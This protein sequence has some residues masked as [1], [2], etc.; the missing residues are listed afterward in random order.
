MRVRAEPWRPPPRVGRD[1]G[2]SAPIGIPAK[3][4][5]AEPS[6]RMRRWPGTTGPG[7]TGALRRGDWPCTRPWPCA[8]SSPPRRGV[9]VAHR[10][11][12]A[13]RPG[14]EGRVGRRGHLV[15]G[16]TARCP[17]GAELAG[18]PAG[19]RK[20]PAGPSPVRRHPASPRASPPSP[21]LRR[22]PPVERRSVGTW[23]PAGAPRRTGAGAA[24]RR[25][26]GRA[27]RQA[28]GPGRVA[29]SSSMPVSPYSGRV[30]SLA[31]LVMRREAV[32]GA[33]TARSASSP[34]GR[35]GHRGPSA[36][37]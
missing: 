3:G 36:M 27:A 4:S 29:L 13:D 17:A 18:T 5:T 23:A 14:A 20:G 37:R 35:A 19:G 7:G 22:L 1:P 16:G 31:T 32:S 26:A 15:G 33:N 2:R 30:G 24:P 6:R 12:G 28:P 21:A 25:Q 8:A 9:A 34:T 11:G 10:Q